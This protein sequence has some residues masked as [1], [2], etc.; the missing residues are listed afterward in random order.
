MTFTVEL[1]HQLTQLLCERPEWRAALR[2]ILL[3]EDILNMPRLMSDLA[4]AQQ[5]TETRVEELAAAQ[6]RTEARV[7]EL[8]AAQLRTQ[9]RMEELAAA[10]QRTEERLDPIETDLQA[11]KNDLGELKGLALEQRHW[12]RPL[13]YFRGIIYKASALTI[14]ELRLLTDAAVENALLTEDEAE[15]IE[16]AG[17]VVRLHL[18]E[19]S[20][21]VNGSIWSS[22]VHRASAKA[23]AR[24]RLQ[25]D[26]SFL[27]RVEN[28]LPVLAHEIP[29]TGCGQQAT[30]KNA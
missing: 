19:M 8:A 18:A 2:S 23:I 22:K 25:L 20:R 12:N 9:A 29:I 21:R 13:Q 28:R 7:E 10:Q 4:A 6:Q 27:K 3:T 15:E 14:E 26:S 30:R 17:V 16:L 24:Y 11:I 1:F 5:R